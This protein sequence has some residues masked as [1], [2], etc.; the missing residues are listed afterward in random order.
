M[1]EFFDIIINTSAGQDKFLKVVQNIIRLLLSLSLSWRHRRRFQWL[2]KS[3]F[4]RL[5][6][7]ISAAIKITRLCSVPGHVQQIGDA[8]CCNTEPALHRVLR[9]LKALGYTAFA[10]GDGAIYLS[11]IASSIPPR[12]KA[13]VAQSSMHA[14]LLATICQFLQAAIILTK[15]TKIGHQCTGPCSKSNGISQLNIAKKQEL[16]IVLPLLSA[17]CDMLSAIAGAGYKEVNDTTLGIL[18]TLSGG[19]SLTL[20]VAK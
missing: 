6:A 20:V 18:G 7:E 13:K 14:L 1:R 10:I 8:I 5:R 12:W 2:D 3:F 16:R 17:A 9:V 4:I 11:T 19:S 15:N